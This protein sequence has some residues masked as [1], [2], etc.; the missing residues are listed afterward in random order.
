M[1][2]A[3]PSG[4]GALDGVRVV[5]TRAV[6]D[7]RSLADGLAAHGARVLV[8]PLVR[9]ESM[10]A[11]AAG[12]DALAAARGYDWIAVTSRHAVDEAARALTALGVVLPASPPPRIAA[13]GTTTAAAARERG[14]R[15]DLVPERQDATTL[16]RT[17]GAAGALHGA[18]VLFPRALDAGE[19]LPAALRAAGATVDEVTLY[20][21][22]SDPAGAA[23]LRALLA[24][25]SAIVTL[26]SGSAARALADRVGVA[27]ATRARL[28]TIGA[29]TSAVAQSLG[30]SVAAE[31]DE[32]SVDGLVRAAMAAARDLE[33]EA[34]A[35]APAEQT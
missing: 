28:V 27:A 6:E 3:P 4:G 23:A 15:V 19:A 24:R 14:W 10:E 26:A 17:M 13:V 1:S 9:T 5:V 20:R 12:R 30:L 29:S 25:E 33:R 16:A 21:T 31:A 8:T 34:G 7:A 2:E 35:S 32:A 18:R 22:T 11:D